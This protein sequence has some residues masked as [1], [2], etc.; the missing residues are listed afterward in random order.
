M[1]IGSAFPR[2][3]ENRYPYVEPGYPLL[4]VLNL[5][6]ASDTPA[7]PLHEGLTSSRSVSGFSS[8]SKLIELPAESFE[9]FLEGPC[10]NAA[11][12]VDTFGMDDDLEKLLEAYKKR[13]LGV[14]LVNGVVGGEPRFSLVGLKDLLSLYQTGQFASDLS[15]QDVSSEIFSLPGT[16]TV[17][18]SLAAMFRLRHRSVFISGDRSYV[19]DRTIIDRVFDPGFLQPHHQQPTVAA[20]DAQ[21]GTLDRTTPT[22]IGPLTGLR[23]AAMKVRSEWG[24]CLTLRDMNALVT[25]WDL[26]MKPWESGKLKIRRR[27]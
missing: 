10:E 9:S 3:L 20:F 5:L 27:S 8:L 17:R 2:L 21:I 11:K 23:A 19:S 12:K 22:E 18:D 16:T 26:V 13:M 15:V 25:P 1:K 7:V 4:T 14:S 24:T 6:R